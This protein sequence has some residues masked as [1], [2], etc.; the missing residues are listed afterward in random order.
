MTACGNERP[1]EIRAFCV[2]SFIDFLEIDLRG[3]LTKRTF[4]K[5][6]HAG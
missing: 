4:E 5:T 2:E 3:I 1:R 6:A